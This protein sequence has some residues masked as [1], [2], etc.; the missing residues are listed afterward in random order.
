MLA[1]LVVVFLTSTVRA[2]EPMETA[3]DRDSGQ[4]GSACCSRAAV[5]MVLP[6]LLPP[7]YFVVRL[8]L[9][10]RSCAAEIRTDRIPL[11]LEFSIKR[12]LFCD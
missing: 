11:A 2:L 8:F 4:T 9:A 1:S 7:F 10:V 12:N 5:R 3:I 6:W